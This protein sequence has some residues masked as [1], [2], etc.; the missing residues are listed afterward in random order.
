MIEDP[1]YFD[2]QQSQWAQ[3]ADLVADT[4]AMHVLRAP[5]TE[6]AWDWYRTYLAA[7][8]GSEPTAQRTKC[9]PG[10]RGASSTAFWRDR[11]QM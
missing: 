1:I 8:G 3:V 6:F 2:S 10:T 11:W 4:A 7:W 5:G 9:L